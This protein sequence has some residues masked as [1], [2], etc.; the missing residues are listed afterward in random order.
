VTLALAE[1]NIFQVGSAPPVTVGGEPVTSTDGIPTALKPVVPNQILIASAA[2]LLEDDG[3]PVGD[4][5][6]AEGGTLVGGPS[7]DKANRPRD[8]NAPAIGAYTPGLLPTQI[9]P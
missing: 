4:G 2:S 6:A 3:T 8:A 9:L 7:V 1:A 5:P